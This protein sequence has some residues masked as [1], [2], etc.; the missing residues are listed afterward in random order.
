MK[1][2]LLLAFL[3]TT[4]PLGA[5]AQGAAGL[6]TEKERLSYAIGFQ[7]GHNLKDQ[8]VDLDVKALS[9]A[10]GDV[11]SGAT[12]KLTAKQMQVAV[13]EFQKK[14]IAERTM[15]AEKNEKAGEAFLAANRKKKGVVELPDGLQYKVLH[16][17]TGPKPTAGDTV[18]VNYRGTLPNGT[19]FDSSYKRGEPAEIPVGQVIP[20]W[21]EA[22][23]QMPVG[24]KWQV[25]IPG[26][27]A[28]GARGAG[29]AIGPNQTLVFDIDLLSI[30]PPAKPVT[31]AD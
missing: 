10:V 27:L 25:V 23:K 26:K 1:K 17:G 6:K 22:L 8:G 21:Q 19:E 9:L 5:W 24:S 29:D 11:L 28:Y 30:K 18:V 20:G 13:M 7:I 15:A 4:L 3:A 12:P 16:K 31:K 14:K 2:K